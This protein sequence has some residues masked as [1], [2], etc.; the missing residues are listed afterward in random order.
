MFD[1]LA[2]VLERPNDEIVHS[3]RCKHGIVGRER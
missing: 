3:S 2:R 1:D